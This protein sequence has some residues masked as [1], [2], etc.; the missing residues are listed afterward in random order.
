MAVR[1]VGT[2]LEGSMA[3]VKDELRAGKEGEGGSWA[4][5]RD[6]SRRRWSRG[7][8]LWQPGNPGRGG[9][10]RGSPRWAPAAWSR[11]SWDP[12]GNQPGQWCLSGPASGGGSRRWA[13]SGP[14]SLSCHQT[15][16]WA[17]AS[18][19]WDQKKVGQVNNY[20]LHLYTIIYFPVHLQLNMWDR[21]IHRSSAPEYNWWFR[22]HNNIHI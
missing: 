2:V 15:L 8:R 7:G 13:V 21:F 14:R 3:A 5:V 16:R 12:G 6:W 20:F 10:C 9:S 22:K 19:K 11:S 1:N 17:T 4:P 18:W